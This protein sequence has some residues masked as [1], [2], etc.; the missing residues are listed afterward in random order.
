MYFEA[1]ESFKHLY[2]CQ[3]SSKEGTRRPQQRQRRIQQRGQEQ[4]QHKEKSHQKK[5]E[6]Q[7]KAVANSQKATTLQS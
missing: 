7:K 6:W 4:K 5:G 1:K 3:G 2:Y